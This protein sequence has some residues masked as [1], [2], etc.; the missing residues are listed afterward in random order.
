[1]YLYNLTLNRASGIQVTSILGFSEA[2]HLHR[3]VGRLVASTT[4]CL[5]PAQCHSLDGHKRTD[6]VWDLLRD[7][8]STRGSVVV[9]RIHLLNSYQRVMWVSAVCHIWQFLGAQGPG[10]CRFEREIAGAATSRRRWQSADYLH[11]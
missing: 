4:S 1:M 5:L 7:R 10:D 11:H 9:C 8:R 3:A 6:A 2:F